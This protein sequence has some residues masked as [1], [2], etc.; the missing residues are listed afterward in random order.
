M[1]VVSACLVG[2]NTR[3]NGASSPSPELIELLL[4]GEVIP[5]CPEQLGGLPT[6]RSPCTLVGGDGFAVLKGEAKAVTRDG[7]EVT[8]KLVRGAQEV[9]KVIKGTGSRRAHLKEG[10][11]SCGVGDTD[12]NWRRKSGY[13]VTAALL[14]S[15]GVEVIGVP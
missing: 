7:E 6:P 14:K 13:G 8:E 9:L 2:L 4:R 15:K 3:Y 1:Q 10:S 5:V 12:C 11:P